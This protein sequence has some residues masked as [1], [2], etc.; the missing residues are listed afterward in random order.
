MPG[1]FE[2]TTNLNYR[3]EQ[4]FYEDLDENNK[5]MSTP[6]A[7]SGETTRSSTPGRMS[8][9]IGEKFRHVF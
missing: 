6:T 7:L 3:K 4:I 5:I 1:L 8:F 9:L 2:I